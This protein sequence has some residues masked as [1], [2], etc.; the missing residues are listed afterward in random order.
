MQDA[1][2]SISPLSVLKIPQQSPHAESPDTQQ[3][4]ERSPGPM[5]TPSEGAAAVKID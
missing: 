4:K 5:E 3:F 1:S 2:A